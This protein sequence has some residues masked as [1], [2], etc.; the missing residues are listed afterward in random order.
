MF[1]VLL[2]VCAG[3]ALASCSAGGEAGD[4]PAPPASSPA[5]A[6]TPSATDSPPEC[7]DEPCYA[8]VEALGQVDPDT[9]TE[10]S[11]MAGSHRSPGL[12]YVIGDPQG[13]SEVAVVQ[14]DGSLV[15]HLE[16]DGLSARN[17]E[18]LA[19]G[20]CGPDTETTCLFI[21]DIGNHV[22]LP[23]LFIYRFPEPDLDELP[24]RVTPDS[25]R[26]TYPGEPTDAEALLVDREGRPIIV[27]KAWFDESTGESGPTQVFRGGR[28]GG[29]LEH[30]SDLRLPAPESPLFADLVGHVVTAADS[31]EDRVIVR[32]YDEIYEYRA[33]DSDAGIGTFAE[34][35]MQRVPAPFQMQSET[36]TYRVGGCGY[37]TTSEL[38]GEIH[39]VGCR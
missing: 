14:E 8:D 11:G 9:V 37:L 22:G 21:G 33:D 12:Y 18:D 7:D 19:V 32:T 5:P 36:I 4:V 2:A 1:R 31:T 24:A 17:A 34:W 26:Y 23:D 28:D 10:V 3:F 15:G 30:L 39:G 25:L 13:T 27:S 35:P 29:T 38:T 16:I 6:N 20:S